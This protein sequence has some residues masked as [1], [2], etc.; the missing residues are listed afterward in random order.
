VQRFSEFLVATESQLVLVAVAMIGLNAEDLR[1]DSLV[2]LSQAGVGCDFQIRVL[3]GPGCER[4]RSMGFCESMPVRK[5]MDGRNMICSVC[6]TRMAL[7][8][9][10][11]EQVLVE[12]AI[13]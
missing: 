11:G 4:L 1:T 10:L 5:L 6:G 13:K 12:P 7:S 2:N 8:R 3:S 9:K